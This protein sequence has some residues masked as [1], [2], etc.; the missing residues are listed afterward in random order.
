M[1]HK[2]HSAWYFCHAFVFVFK[3]VCGGSFIYIALF[4][5]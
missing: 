5:H 1:V 4:T 3:A 2:G